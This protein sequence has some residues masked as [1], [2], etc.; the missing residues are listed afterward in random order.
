VEGLDSVN[1]RP[2]DL[3]EVESSGVFTVEVDTTGLSGTRVVPRTATLGV[4]VE[5]KIERVLSDLPVQLR[6]PDPDAVLVVEPT[7]VRVTLVGA[8][9]LVGRVDL[10]YLTAWVA[11]ELLRDMAPG[12]ERRVDLRIEGVPE[13]VQGVPDRAQVTVRRTGVE[14]EGDPGDRPPG[15]MPPEDDPSGGDG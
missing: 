10:A 1:L 9:T 13:L 5:D 14:L 6:S 7:S 3:T 2:L 11:P 8:R 15:G 4:R 12:E